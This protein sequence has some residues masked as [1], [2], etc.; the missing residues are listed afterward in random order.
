MCITPKGNNLLYTNL[1][2]S[3]YYTCKTA[4]I[5]GGYIVEIFIPV[6]GENALVENS[7]MGLEFSIDYY[8]TDKL[9]RAAY[10]YL[11]GL[12]TYWDD[13]GDL[14]PMQLIK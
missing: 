12:G 5:D 7:F 13:V 4:L 8:R 9:P 2:I 14:C 1:D 6:L 11:T 3:E 10:T